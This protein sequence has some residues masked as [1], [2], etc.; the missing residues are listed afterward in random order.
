MESYLLVIK[1]IELFLVAE[2]RIAE[3]ERD[4]ERERDLW[5]RLIQD[6]NCTQNKVKNIVLLRR[7]EVT[8]TLRV[9]RVYGDI[10]IN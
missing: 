1:L 2:L 10:S 8:F 7:R 6:S 3:S 4:M 5:L 9:Y